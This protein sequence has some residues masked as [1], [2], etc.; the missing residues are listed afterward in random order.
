[1][2]KKMKKRMGWKEIKEV[3]REEKKQ[4]A[5]FLSNL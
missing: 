3:G 5:R 1:M 4:Y 2:K